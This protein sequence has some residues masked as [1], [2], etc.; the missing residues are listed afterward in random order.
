MLGFI[1][2]LPR[3]EKF[4]FSQRRE[5]QEFY[6]PSAPVEQQDLMEW[7]KRVEFDDGTE[8]EGVSWS[9]VWAT[10]FEQFSKTLKCSALRWRIWVLLDEYLVTP[11]AWTGYTKK[12][13]VH[14]QTLMVS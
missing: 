8:A 1:A 5:D 12:E 6:C 13:V 4:W 11:L 2:V 3:S 10:G 9:N 14:T 7:W